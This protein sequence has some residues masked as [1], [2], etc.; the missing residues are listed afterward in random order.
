MKSIAEKINIGLDTIIFIDD[1]KAN[2]E[3][4]KVAMPDV[5]VIDLPGDPS[6]YVKTLMEFNDFNTFQIAEEDKKRNRF[7]WSPPLRY[8][9]L[10]LDTL[11]LKVN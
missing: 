5:Y 8:Y 10:F 7:Q 9:T 1:D 3:M 6:D 11:L 2:R 4:V